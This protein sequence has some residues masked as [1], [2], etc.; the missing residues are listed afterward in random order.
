MLAVRVV[1]KH[2]QVSMVR[3]GDGFLRGCMEQPDLD[4]VI[5]E[6][7]ELLGLEVAV[8]FGCLLLYIFQLLQFKQ[9]TA[10]F[11]LINSSKISIREIGISSYNRGLGIFIGQ[12]TQHKETKPRCPK[13]QLNLIPHQKIR[14]HTSGMPSVG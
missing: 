7:P 10:R 11:T 9:F 5:G 3:L 2:P 13:R 4:P 8:R 6:V 1:A 12:I 14:T